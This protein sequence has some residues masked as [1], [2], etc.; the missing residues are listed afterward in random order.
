MAL[1]EFIKMLNLAKMSWIGHGWSFSQL[2]FRT[3]CTS[4]TVLFIG[5]K[6]MY[7]KETLFSHPYKHKS[8]S[9]GSK[10]IACKIVLESFV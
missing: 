7:Q 8:S 6:K 1:V 3:N 9:N 4:S 2:C 5:K 10:I